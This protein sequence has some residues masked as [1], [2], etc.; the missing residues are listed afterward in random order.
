MSYQR[1]LNF[2]KIVNDEFSDIVS[3]VGL[4]P[5]RL[6]ITLVDGSWIEVRYP[7][8]GKF[9]FHWQRGNKIYRIDTAPHHK[10]I[11]T[12]PRHIHFEREDNVIEDF[13]TKAGDEPEEDF[14]NFMKWVRKL[15]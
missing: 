14:R 10:H 1:L 15:F 7:V 11:K 6:R 8:K 9:S 5:D 12:Y 3:D 13:V 2:V 4:Y